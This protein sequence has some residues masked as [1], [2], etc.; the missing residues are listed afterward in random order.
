MALP[1]APLNATHKALY[2]RDLLNDINGSAYG[3]LLRSLS[4]I[5]AAMGIGL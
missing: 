5:T 4:V 3:T 1:V 2:V